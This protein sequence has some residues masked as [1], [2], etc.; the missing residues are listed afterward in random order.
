MTIAMTPTMR[1][2]TTVGD[3]LA[4]I[5]EGR[6]QQ[7]ATFLT[8]A[9]SEEADFWTRWAGA[10]FLS[11]QFV[12]WFRQECALLETLRP[13]M[14]DE[15]ARTIA[16]ARAAL[17][18]TTEALMDGGRRR[19]NGI[20]TARLVRRF[21]DQ[22]ALWFVEVELATDR[23]ETADLPSGPAAALSAF[24]ITPTSIASCSSAPAVGA[25]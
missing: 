8:P 18:P 10:R 11:D 17:E 9:L 22:L 2:A 23:I 12:A 14:P 20:R 1:T 24:R 19:E 13:L 6:M 5:H 15:G 25:T 4:L 21:L 3:E 16:A 7:V